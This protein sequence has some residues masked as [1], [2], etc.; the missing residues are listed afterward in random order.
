M[1][2]AADPGQGLPS[3]HGILAQAPVGSFP[4]SLAA[5]PV[6]TTDRQGECCAPSTRTLPTSIADNDVDSQVYL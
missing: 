4:G 1:E 6:M 3:D 5:A 2:T